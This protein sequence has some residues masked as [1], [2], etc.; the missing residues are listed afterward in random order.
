MSVAL[1]AA[2]R[3][4]ARNCCECVGP[5][6]ADGSS[7][8]PRCVA[9]DAHRA[10][11]RRDGGIRHRAAAAGTMYLVAH[12]DLKSARFGAIF[13]FSHRWPHST[14]SITSRRSPDFSASQRTPS[15]RLL[16]RVQD[17]GR[18]STVWGLGP[19][20]AFAALA[21]GRILRGLQGDAAVLSAKAF[22]S[23]LVMYI[24]FR[25]ASLNRGSS[26]E[27]AADCTQLR[28]HPRRSDR[29]GTV[30]TRKA[31]ALHDAGASVHVIAP[32]VS[33]LWSRQRNR[34]RG[35]AS[36][37]GNIRARTISA[38]QTG[39]CRYRFP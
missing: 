10:E 24:V 11:L 30:G 38:M 36:T 33:P 37:P 4:T 9:R 34:A 22:A 18:S 31:L 14:E 15:C 2:P 8:R 32:S 7:G 26:S 17:R 12:R 28:G 27:R 5:H 25:A 3:G 6:A 13:R 23:V 1:V 21:L 35:C 39:F 19:G 29:R 16:D 20:S